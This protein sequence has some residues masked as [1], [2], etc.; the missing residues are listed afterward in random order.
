MFVWKEPKINKKE[1]GDGPFKKTQISKKRN[2]AEG[3]EMKVCKW[4]K[5][6]DLAFGEKLSQRRICGKSSHSKE[7]QIQS[8]TLLKNQWGEQWVQMG[9]FFIQ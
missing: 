3:K 9:T 2:D 7:S 1:A 8:P 6:I 4:E 5:K